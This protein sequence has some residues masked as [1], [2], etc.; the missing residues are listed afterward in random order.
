[1]FCLP[2]E[3]IVFSENEEEH[4]KNVKKV[5]ERLKQANLKVKLSKCQIAVKKIEYLSHIIED[6]S[7]A[8]NPKKVAHVNEMERP[9]SV[10]QFKGFLGFASYYRKYIRDFAK[11]A[12]PFIRATLLTTKLVWNDDSEQAF[13]KLKQILTSELVLQLPDFK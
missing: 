9:K 10:K 3:V 1:L 6:G 5:I 4:F 2:Y 8:T 7:I 11:I 13:C 12:S